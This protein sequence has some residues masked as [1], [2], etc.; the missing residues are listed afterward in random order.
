MAHLKSFLLD[1]HDPGWDIAF[2][3]DAHAPPTL[4]QN[5]ALYRHNGRKLTAMIAVE[6]NGFLHLSVSSHT[7]LP[8]TNEE[9]QWLADDT[10]LSTLCFREAKI[11]D[12]EKIREAV[13]KHTGSPIHPIVRHFYHRIE[14][15]VH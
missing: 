6:D 10:M 15:E 3:G 2:T 13:K 5:C 1:T 12:I 7:G 8:P 14:G 9:C 11:Q 4:P